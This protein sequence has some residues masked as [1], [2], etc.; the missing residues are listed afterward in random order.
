MRSGWPHTQ[1]DHGRLP[2][3]QPQ[4][5]FG[6]EISWPT[7]YSR[8]EYRDGG[9]R[10]PAAQPAV[11]Q[12]EHPYAA[13]SAAGYGDDGYSDPGYDG[14]ASQDA[15]VAGTRTVRGFIEPAPAQA[16][17]PQAGYAQPGYPQAGYPDQGYSEPAYSRQQSWD[18]DQPLRY[19][20]ADASYPAQDGYRPSGSHPQPDGYRQQPDGYGQPEGYGQPDGYG[21]AAYS[22]PTYDPADYNGSA[23][24]RPGI[25]GPGYDLSGIIG[26][27]E[28]DAVGYDEPSYDRLSYDDPRYADA[29][30]HGDRRYDPQG[31]PRLDET[32]FDMPRFDETRLDSLWLADEDIRHDE[33][34]GYG[35]DGFAGDGRLRSGYADFDLPPSGRFDETRLDLRVGDLGIDQTRFD[36]PAYDETRI[37]SVRA[38]GPGADFRPAPTGLLAPPQDQPLSW[39]GEASLD[40]H[41]LDVD[42][43]LAP[44]P[45]AFARTA[46]RDD[47]TRTRRT[48]GRRRGRSRDRRQ[49]IALGAIAVVAAGAIG[50]VLMKFVFSGP[51]GPAHNVVAPNRVDAFTRMPNLEKQM[52][53]EAL[54]QDVMKTSAG[55]ATNVVSA[56]YQVGS[57]APGGNA[58]IFM[59]V[60]GKLSSAAPATSIENFT[61]TYPGAKVV[62]AGAL[63]GEAACAEA[64]SNGEG[65]AMCVWFDNDSFGELVSPTMTTA[66]LATTLDTVRPNLEL[67]AK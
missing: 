28:F 43:E 27:D 3:D 6:P 29:T 54:R 22:A 66:K 37:D 11:G 17:Y 20:S 61:Q 52:K 60:G 33:P 63:G 50:G 57:T 42:E 35:N 12:G 19:D 5:P 59:F 65:V 23:H 58:Q 38:L 46:E 48:T 47:D 4:A 24:S 8:L 39:A 64:Q 16:G 67:Y 55:Q 9:Y 62:P 2:A 14:P 13:F 18:Y 31:G 45:A 32:R 49:W 1:G 15:G 40:D 10:Y 36:M 44:V 34:I 30:G 56:V 26:T 25:D 51:S 21:F 53:V 41:Y 7:G